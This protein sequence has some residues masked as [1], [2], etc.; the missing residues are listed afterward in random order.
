LPQCCRKKRTAATAQTQ[1]S[2]G[3]QRIVATVAAIIYKI[4]K[5][6]IKGDNTPTNPHNAYTRKKVLLLRQQGQQGQQNKNNQKTT[7]HDRKKT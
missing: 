1:S 4:I 2:K 3:I 7:R 6:R 5:N